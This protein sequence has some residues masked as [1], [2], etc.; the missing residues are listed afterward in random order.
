VARLPRIDITFDEQNPFKKAYRVRD[1]E[2][3][4]GKI[5]R[6]ATPQGME[7]YFA[8]VMTS[9]YSPGSAD[10]QELQDDPY[11]LIRF[12]FIMGTH[13]AA[14]P[15]FHFVTELNGTLTDNY[16][17]QRRPVAIYCEGV[18]WLNWALQML[19]G[20]RKEF[21]GI[22]VPLISYPADADA[23]GYLPRAIASAM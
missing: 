20:K 14:M 1:V 17:T 19:E 12:V 22:Q 11:W 3:K 7:D 10:S 8:P 16:P 23:N 18:K 4:G 15:P 5:D 6:K 9:V 21:L 2:E 13:F